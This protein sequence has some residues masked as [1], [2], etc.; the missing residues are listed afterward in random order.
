MTTRF[1]ITVHKAARLFN[2]AACIVSVL[3]LLTFP[4]QS[5]HQFTNHFRTPEVR[6][7]IER[8]TP[9]TQS[10]S[11][12]TECIPYQALLPNLI[13]PVDEGKVPIRVTNFEFASQVPLSRL[14]SRLKLGP[15]RSDGPD[16]LL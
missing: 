8:H 9:V 4:M 5:A 3:T 6:R 12:V 7:S 2:L 10:E 16:P 13:I 1:H 11:Q 14:L 15:S